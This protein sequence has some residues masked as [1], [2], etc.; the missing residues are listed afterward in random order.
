MGGR[1][2]NDVYAQEEFCLKNKYLVICIHTGFKDSM[3][4]VCVPEDVSE[5]INFLILY[6][7]F[8]HMVFWGL[9]TRVA[10]V[11]NCGAFVSYDSITVLIS[12]AGGN[13]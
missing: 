6:L 13:G 12:I 10:C 2:F 1:L 7:P 8:P 5:L 4:C 11:D 3:L 9:E